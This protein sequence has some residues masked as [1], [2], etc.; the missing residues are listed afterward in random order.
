[1]NNN[2]LKNLKL[3]ANQ[4][5]KEV[6]VNGKM[7]EIPVD[8]KVEKLKNLLDYEHSNKY[9]V[10][11]INYSNDYKTPVL[12]AGKS[13]LLGYTNETNNIFKNLPV[14]IFDD[15]TTSQQYINF[16]FKVKSGAMKIL[17]QKSNVD[18][19]LI[20]ILMKRIQWDTSNHKRYWISEYQNLKIILPSTILEQTLIAS[21]LTHI[22][23]YKEKIQEQL[24]REKKMFLFFSQELLSGRLRFEENN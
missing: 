11:D 3:H 22:D 15:F 7:I 2:F 10:D 21:Y 8:W 24:E 16:E 14:I 13:L 19:K 17:K 1:M 5:W 4:E 6:K 12:T 9:I 23:E 20:N 18:L